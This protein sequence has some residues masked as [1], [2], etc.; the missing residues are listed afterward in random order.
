MLPITRH[1]TL[2]IPHRLALAA[3]AVCLV[4]SFT[5][6]RTALEESVQENQTAAHQVDSLDNP[7]AAVKPSERTSAGSGKSGKSSLKLL[8]WFTGL[9]H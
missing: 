6:D 4:L 8:P 1:R 5:V 7:A 3:A 9:A 2:A